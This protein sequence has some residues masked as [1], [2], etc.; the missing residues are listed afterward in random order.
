MYSNLSLFMLLEKTL[1]V[2][3]LYQNG[4]SA[5]ADLLSH[6]HR[7]AIRT[8]KCIVTSAAVKR[9]LSKFEAMNCLNERPHSGRQSTSANASRTVQEEIE[10]AAVSS[11]HGKPAF[12]KSHVALT[13][14]ALLFG[15][16]KW[17]ILL[18]YPRKI[19]LHH[20]LLPGDLVKR[21]S[22]TMWT[23]QKM[24]EDCDWLFNML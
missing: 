12:V 5:N 2:K 19:Q 15:Q 3:L 6:R 10:I 9:M 16:Q 7:M 17:R 4:K 24:S 8:G 20:E 1:L 21:S 18:C 13:F 22:F 14:H 23:F 11:T